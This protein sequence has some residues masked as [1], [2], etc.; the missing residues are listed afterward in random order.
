[1]KRTGMV[2]FL[3]IVLAV[4]LG[5]RPSSQ[6][7]NGNGNAFGHD[8]DDDGGTLVLRAVLKGAEEPPA[9]STVGRGTFKATLDEAGTMLEYELNYTGL[10]GDVQQ[11]H[12]HLGQKGANGG[13]AAFLCTNQ[14][15]GPAGTPVC[16]GPNSG[17]VTGTILAAQIVGPA[18]Q[19]LPPGAFEEFLRAIDKSLTYV[20]VHSSLVPTGE[21]RGQISVRR[22]DDN[23]D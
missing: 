8:D 19:G 2:L 4:T 10:E 13:V 17:A 5:A 21:I 18:G 12:I 14:G 15:N 11:A 23:D 6:N 16:P 3:G 9:V 20:N 7:K 1:M 22:E